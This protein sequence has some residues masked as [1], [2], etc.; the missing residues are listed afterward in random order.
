MNL[1][2]SG[3]QPSDVSDIGSPNSQTREILSYR[4]DTNQRHLV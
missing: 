4:D 2:R 3:S 1:G